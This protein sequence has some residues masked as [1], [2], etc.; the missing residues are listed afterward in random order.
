MRSEIIAQLATDQDY[1]YYLRENPIWYKVL[2]IHPE[3]FKDFLNEYK[4]SR[5]K[6]FIDRIDDINMAI[7]LAESFLKKN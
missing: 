3:K 7:N 6:R 1:F 2:T 5:K 4:I